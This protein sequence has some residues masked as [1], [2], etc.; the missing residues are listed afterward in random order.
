MKRCLSLFVVVFAFACKSQTAEPTEVPA[1]EAAPVAPVGSHPACVGP[2]VEGAAE[3]LKVGAAEWEF[4]GSTVRMKSGVNDGALTIGAV[5]DIKE[6]TDENKSNLETLVAWFE[7]EAVD[8]IVVAGDTGE[9]QPQ[10]ENVLTIL[11]GANVPVFNIIGNREGKTDYGKA[12]ASLRP[13]NVFDLNVVRRIDTPVADIV[14]MPGYFNPSYIHS[15]DGCQYFA[16]D[17]AALSALVGTCDSPVVLVS[18]GGPRQEGP[19]ALDRTAEGANVGDP[20]LTR[21]LEE[22]KVP[23]GIFG[24]IHEAGGRATDRAGENVLAEKDFHTE[25]YLNP[26]PADGVRWMM[27]DG[28]LSVGMGAVMK[29]KDGLAAYKTKRLGEVA[30]SPKKK[31][32]K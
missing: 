28:S 12:M 26:G 5:A 3:T 9:T 7:K 23:F 30:E 29:I 6:D 8:L 14:S 31:K 15:D 25:L 4:A 11:A 1:T 18:H 10:I 2:V 17:V 20:A 19:E 32:K 27:N 16:E 21:L 22:R 13:K 24:N